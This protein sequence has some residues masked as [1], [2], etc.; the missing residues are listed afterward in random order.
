[1]EIQDYRLKPGQTPNFED[2]KQFEADQASQDELKNELLPELV[3]QLYDWHVKLQA[4]EKQA[5]VLALQA[6]DAAGKDEIITFVFS[7]L[8]AQGLKVA[9]TGKPSETDQAH[10]FLWRHWDKLPERGQIGILNRS[11]YEDV[12]SLIVHGPDEQVPMSH[13]SLEEEVD[14]R[15]QAIRHMEEYLYD[16]GFHVLKLFPYVSPAV[17]KERLLERMKNEDKQWEFSFSD[18]SDRDKWEKFHQ[19]YEYILQETSTDKAPWYV[20]PGDNAW[21]TRFVAGKIVLAELKEMNPQY[22]ELSEEDQ[23]KIDQAIKELEQ[24]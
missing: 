15:L 6:L 11:Y 16:S 1:M 13:D 10:D 18:L 3:D 19:A 22:P 20:L 2:L 8:M 23:E 17:Q 5:I 14:F 4:E 12:V 24:D 9:A 21:F 7:H